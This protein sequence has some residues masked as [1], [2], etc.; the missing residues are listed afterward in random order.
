[1]TC[2]EGFEQADR[3][4]YRLINRLEQLGTDRKPCHNDLVPENFV[5]SGEGRMYLIDW[6]YSGYN[7][8]MWDLA[9]HL[10][11]S[12]FDEDEE[13]LFFQYYFQR[14]ITPQ[15]EETI[16]IYEICQDI[17]WSALTVLKEHDGEDFGT[18]G[19][20]RLA[21]ALEMGNRYSKSYGHTD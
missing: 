20:D 17:L 21:R 6:E 16:R 1:M 11:E 5:M 18:Y 15:E 19:T 12:G 10:L 13:E 8:P 3:L 9:S 14:E 7:D 2:Y 4:F